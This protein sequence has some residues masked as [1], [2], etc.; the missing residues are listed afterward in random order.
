VEE[1]MPLL[2]R[3][4][5]VLG[6]LALSV[7][8]AQ[9]ALTPPPAKG[10]GGKVVITSCLVMFALKSSGS[11][12]TNA[13]MFNT[14]NRSEVTV[15]KVYELSGFD[16]TSFQ[17]VTD[18]MCGGAPAALTAAGYEV[19]SPNTDHYSWKDA[20]ERGKAGPLEEKA[21]GTEYRV[22]AP[23]GA[24]II[25]PMVVGGMG[26]Q[27]LTW[28]ETTM[29][30]HLNAKP[31]NIIYTVDF[32]ALQDQNRRSR[33]ADQNTARLTASVNLTVGATVNT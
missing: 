20:L 16:T 3:P 31:V 13:G 25:D 9:A 1:F 27:R 32:V 17:R 24:T 19:V 7:I 33:V 21:N 11:S 8:P 14:D 26:A 23:T 18:Q 5:A 10:P 4:A 15:T 28:S 30:N 6:L 12:A 2:T 29:G 22:Y